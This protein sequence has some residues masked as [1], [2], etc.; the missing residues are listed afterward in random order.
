MEE[1]YKQWQGRLLFCMPA[2]CLFISSLFGTALGNSGGCCS[3]GKDGSAVWDTLG[4]SCAWDTLFFMSQVTSC[5]RLENSVSSA[6]PCEH[7][8]IMSE[9]FTLQTS[10]VFRAWLLSDKKDV[11]WICNWSLRQNAWII[12]MVT[13]HKQWLRRVCY[14]N[15]QLTFISVYTCLRCMQC[16]PNAA[17]VMCSSCIVMPTSV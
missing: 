8:A 7:L 15:P 12:H 9:S 3:W 5:V 14:A 2:F 16:L 11:A 6:F 17:W 10:S 1:D 4:N 13:I